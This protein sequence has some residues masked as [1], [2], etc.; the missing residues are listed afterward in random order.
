MPMVVAHPTIPGAFQVVKLPSET[1]DSIGV[2]VALSKTRTAATDSILATVTLGA[3]INVA[4]DVTVS[5]NPN[6]GSQVTIGAF[7]PPTGVVTSFTFPIN[8]AKTGA[9]AEYPIVVTVDVSALTGTGTGS[10][11]FV[12]DKLAPAVPSGFSAAAGKG[13]VTLV[14]S[15]VADTDIDH[16]NIYESATT[17]PPGSPAHQ[18]Y[19][20]FF[21]ETGLTPGTARHYWVSAVDITG[22]ESALSTRADATPTGDIAVVLT[23]K[24]SLVGGAYV[25]DNA[26]NDGLFVALDTAVPFTSLTF[27][28][29]RASDGSDASSIFAFSNLL[30]SDGGSYKSFNTKVTVSDV[31]TET[32]EF[33]LRC[34]VSL[35]G[36]TGGGEVSVTIRT[37]TPATLTLGSATGLIDAILVTWTA[38]IDQFLD[39][40]TVYRN[41][42]SNNPVGATLLGV[43]NNTSYLDSSIPA[44]TQP[45]Y[46][47]FVTQTD[48][49]KP[50]NESPKQTAGSGEVGT[51]RQ[52]I[53]GDV[54]AAAIA[55]SQTNFSIELF[56]TNAFTTVGN[57]FVAP[58]IIAQDIAAQAIVATKLSI[59]SAAWDPGAFSSNSP[60][61]GKVS[62]VGFNL[63]KSGIAYSIVANGTGVTKKVIW[64]D[65]SVSTT[66]LQADDYSVAP[67]NGSPTAGSF[68]AKFNPDEDV[69]LGFNNSGTFQE[70]WGGTVID[71]NQ[72]MAS[73]ISANKINVNTLSAIVADIGTIT[74]GIIEDNSGNRGIRVTASYSKPSGWAGTS[75]YFIDLAASNS[76][77]MQAGTFLQIDIGSGAQALFKGNVKADSITLPATGTPLVT[78]GTDDLAFASTG[79]IA[80]LPQ[81]LIQSAADYASALVATKDYISIGVPIL[82]G[83]FGETNSLTLY[84]NSFGGP[85]AYLGSY[86]TTGSGGSSFSPNPFS[87]T[88][89]NVSGSSV[90]TF[91]GTTLTSTD[92]TL[93]GGYH[94]A[95]NNTYTFDWSTTLADVWT[96]GGGDE[97]DTT[98]TAVSQYSL[99]GSTWTTIATHV[100]T[101]SITTTSSLS[102]TQA[103]SDAVVLSPPTHLYFQ[104]LFTLQ[105][106]CSD[107]S[108][109]NSSGT[110]TVTINTTDVSWVFSGSGGF[111]YRN[112]YLQGS[113]SNPHMVL[114]PTGS[115]P[116]AAA[117]TGSIVFY[118]DSIYY[119][120]GSAWKQVQH[121]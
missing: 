110:S 16:Y 71:G 30:V 37:T 98:A 76:R 56:G 32:A 12:V 48:K 40:Y 57:A 107:R 79:A 104:V 121:V 25:F 35:S 96:I 42:S 61:G 77:F 75:G 102:Q 108:L 72:L 105:V 101:S 14:W 19:G 117:A 97:V 59:V 9:A 78:I 15:P 44:G 81:L 67:G 4:T 106:T 80:R 33:I 55:L 95:S 83:I 34:D 73:S 52:I 69:V 21:A 13:S 1:T 26:L 63:V 43:T 36:R 92:I 24:E 118:N 82:G 84:S 31:A 38:S 51:P 66:S 23:L 86:M 8:I 64:W 113:D 116:T 45:T 2:S 10:A 109:S 46:F 29:R 99:D 6:Y 47:Y 70:Q 100:L 18:V 119:Y 5:F 93:T 62:W 11:Q 28:A 103:F 112:L 3:S 74:A 22:N 89:Q 53:T 115:A 20:T 120:N 90:S 60:S 94:S 91:T 39:H 68:E 114:N 17:T 65:K 58:Q 85:T 87:P 7:T 49:A 41:T 27:S 88:T 111:S 54:Q 50:G